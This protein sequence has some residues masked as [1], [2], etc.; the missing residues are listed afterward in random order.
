V[1]R[2]QEYIKFTQPMLLPSFVDEF[3]CKKRMQKLAT[4]PGGNSSSDIFT[5]SY[6]S[7]TCTSTMLC[8]LE[9]TCASSKEVI[10]VIYEVQTM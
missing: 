6:Q 10:I 4:K 2:N 1:E 7:K 9:K 3:E 8:M 5:K